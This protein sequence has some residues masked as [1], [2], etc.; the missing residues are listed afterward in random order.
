[1]SINTLDIWT[2][3]IVVSA[4]CRVSTDKDDQA[5]SLESQKKYFTD[6]IT[7]HPNWT[8]GEVYYD[9]GIS[10][11]SIKKRKNFNRLINDAMLGKVQYIITKEVSRFARNTVDTLVFTRQLKDRGVGVYFVLDNINTLDSDGEFRLTIMASLAQEESRKTSERVKWGQKRKMEAGVVFG[12]DM[13]GY[14][15]KDGIISIN[16]DEVEIVKQV[17]NKFLE[18]ESTVSISEFLRKSQAKSR[19]SKSWWP[20]AVS[21]MLKNVKYVGDLCQRKTVT[22]NYLTKHRKYNLNQDDLVYI[23]NHHDG[24]IDRETWDKVQAEIARR[25]TN[26]KNGTKQTTK[27]WC[28]GK[29]VCGECGKNFVKGLQYN[30]GKRAVTNWRCAESFR[31]GRKKNSYGFEIGCNNLSANNK[32][33]VTCVGEAIKFVKLNHLSLID[34]LIK[35]IK[36]VQLLSTAVD[37]APLLAQIDKID[38]QKRKAIDLC[39]DGLISNEDLKKQN[40]HYDNE[41]AVL[42]KQLLEAKQEKSRLEQQNFES[43]DFIASIQNIQSMEDD[44]LELFKEV[45]SKLIIFG[46]DKTAIAYLHHLP[47]GIKFKY[48]TS[49]Y[50]EQY[51]VQVE[52]LGLVYE[53]DIPA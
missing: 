38:S 5:N 44:N 11:T 24:I 17:F 37:T 23:R 21:K 10:G 6:F 51:K 42:E 9:E 46:R 12:H 18:G 50:C 34:D 15:I 39:I 33:L 2:Q 8:L 43:Q 32:I 36:Q 53:D 16:P 30:A 47:F 35:E 20:S 41:I 48:A 3:K 52:N 45:L 19:W 31:N 7:N 29:I 28:S 4:Y 40:N 26:N 22:T 27:H 14:T 1:M 13:L 49:G 25:T